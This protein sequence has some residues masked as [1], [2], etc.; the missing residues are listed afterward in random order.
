MDDV[1]LKNGVEKV[2]L[3]KYPI[4]WIKSFFSI[5]RL[6]WHCDRN[7]TAMYLKPNGTVVITEGSHALEC[8]N[9]VIANTNNND[10]DS[11]TDND[12]K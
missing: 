6:S 4:G 3:F 1:S 9:R 2:T 7:F 11:R 12:L 8:F 5:A 10:D